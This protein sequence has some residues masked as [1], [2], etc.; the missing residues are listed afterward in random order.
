MFGRRQLLYKNKCQKY[1]RQATT[2]IHY[3]SESYWLA[4]GH[5]FIFSKLDSR[6][7]LR[8]V[9]MKL[10]ITIINYLKYF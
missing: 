3:T 2:A 4:A 9:R 6:G 8:A 10:S 7:E 5:Y 1:E